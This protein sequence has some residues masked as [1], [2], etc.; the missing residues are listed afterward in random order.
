MGFEGPPQSHVDVPDADLLTKGKEMM[1][2]AYSMY[3]QAL[4]M[5]EAKVGP[6]TAENIFEKSN[7]F[8]TQ[9]EA[10]ALCVTALAQREGSLPSIYDGGHDEELLVRYRTGDY[11]FEEDALKSAE[12]I[13][14]KLSQ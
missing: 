13:V 10:D 11:S 5:L 3:S 8:L 1:S 6:V 9:D 14:A 4:T 2:R 7:G 12:V